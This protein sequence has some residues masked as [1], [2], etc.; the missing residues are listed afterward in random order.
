MSQLDLVTSGTMQLLSLPN[1]LDGELRDF[2]YLSS[3]PEGSGDIYEI[4]KIQNKS[5]SKSQSKNKTFGSYF[6]NSQVVQDGALYVS[7]R[8]DPLFWVLY[9]LQTQNDLDLSKWNPSDQV[10][11]MLPTALQMA[12]DKTQL[13][14]ILDQNDELC[15]DTLLYKFSE[16]RT[17]AWLKAKYERS[18]L[19]VEAKFVAVQQEHQSQEFSAIDPSLNLGGD[20][21]DE[22]PTTSQ[23]GNTLASQE[24][25]VKQYALDL[26]CQY[27]N[28][29]WR[30]KFCLH[31]GL[32]LDTGKKRQPNTPENKRSWESYA[33]T[34]TITPEDK[35]ELKKQKTSA[36]QTAGLKKLA[37][38]ST[39]GMKSL[40]SFF[41]AAKKTTNK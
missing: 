26:V 5:H 23:A 18:L 3:S 21:N 13:G 28:E 19:A 4:Q 34:G 16:T 24:M 7:S 12:L 9:Y 29:E 36:A 20:E 11:S 30:S 27:I 10:L 41:G 14:H 32:E 35:Q 39:K 8:V 1:P 15:E 2:M 25:Q 38:V 33:T 22:N 31:L 40:A 6:V 17:L 37:K